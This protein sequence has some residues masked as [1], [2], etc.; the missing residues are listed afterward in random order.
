MVVLGI[1]FDSAQDNAA[2]AEKHGFNFP[3]LCD[4]DRAI[5]VAYGAA[6]DASARHAKRF[7]FVIDPEGVIAEALDTSDPAG[8]A[9]TLL[10]EQPPRPGPV[11]RAMSWLER[12]LR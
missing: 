12:K 2:F 11:A 5:G 3:L 7:T 10:G 4:T 8:Q 9:C 1:S 6:D